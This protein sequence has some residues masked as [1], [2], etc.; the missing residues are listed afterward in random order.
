MF[1]IDKA[2][3][4]T[5]VSKKFDLVSGYHHNEIIG[6]HITLLNHPLT[7]ANL[8]EDMLNTL[9]TGQTW[10]GETIH[11]NKYKHE[12]WL[13]LIVT[14]EF[15]EINEMEG[16]TA[17]AKNITNQ[18]IIERISITDEL[19]Q[20]YNR[21]KIED[22]LKQEIDRAK[23]Y[24]SIFS[25]IFLDIDKFKT[26]NDLYGHSSGDDVLVQLAATLKKNLRETDFV[27]RWGGEEFIIVCAGTQKAG[28]FNLAQTLR[29]LIESTTFPIDSRVTISL[30]VAQYEGSESISDLISRVDTALYQAKEL[31]RNRVEMA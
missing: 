21:R 17:I 25:V 26:I 31:G 24:K 8:Y 14:P 11:F 10:E 7:P 3:V 13:D 12:F 16:Y 27:G 4:F 18:K 9:E 2:G 1:S 20:I 30:G 29:S 28:A 22:I 19:T 23:R 6:K 15:N 5:Y